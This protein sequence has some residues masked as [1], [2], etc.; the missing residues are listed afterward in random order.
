MRKGL[1]CGLIGRAKD[2]EFADE[3]EK[4]NPCANELGI[5]LSLVR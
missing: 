5:R 4:G 3:W 1:N 2:A